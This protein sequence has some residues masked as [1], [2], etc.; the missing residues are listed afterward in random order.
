MHELEVE[1]KP[2]V[3]EHPLD[4]KKGLHYSWPIITEYVDFDDEDFQFIHNK[5]LD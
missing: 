4:N 5:I 1:S 3:L 2:I